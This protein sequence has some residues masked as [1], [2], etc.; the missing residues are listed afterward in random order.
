[1]SAPNLP[2][3][4]RLVQ[5]SNG[6]ITVVLQ[7]DDDGCARIRPVGDRARREAAHPQRT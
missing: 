1:M 6:E 7:A 4:H 3:G 2:A 5:R